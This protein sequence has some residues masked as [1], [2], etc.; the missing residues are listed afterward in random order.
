MAQWLRIFAKTAN[1]VPMTGI[2]LGTHKVISGCGFLPES[3]QQGLHQAI[4]FIARVFSKSRKRTPDE[5]T[6]LR[7]IEDGMMTLLKQC[8]AALLSRDGLARKFALIQSAAEKLHP[9]FLAKFLG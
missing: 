6:G 3:D 5:E 8:G 4:K 9:E 2:E 7:L 1:L